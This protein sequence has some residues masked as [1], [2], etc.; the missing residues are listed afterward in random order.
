MQHITFIYHL[1][2]HYGKYPQ[3]QS[4]IYFNSFVQLVGSANFVI[5]FYRTVTDSSSDNLIK[6]NS[7]REKHSVIL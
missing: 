3:C 6:L 1:L 5:I 7:K 2:L 4:Y